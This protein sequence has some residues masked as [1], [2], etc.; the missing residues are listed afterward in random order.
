MSKQLTAVIVGRRESYACPDVM[1]FNTPEGALKHAEVALAQ[2]T[3]VVRYPLVCQRDL[4]F[5]TF[6]PKLYLVVTTVDCFD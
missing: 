2:A 5:A 4:L 6:E 1:V 3:G